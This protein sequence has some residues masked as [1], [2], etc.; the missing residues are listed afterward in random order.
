MSAAWARHDSAARRLVLTLHVLPG[1]RASAIAGVHGDALKVRI[2]APAAENRANAA[3]IDFLSGLFG[4][5]KSAINIR[6]GAK[7]R[8]KLV[9]IAGGPELATKLEPLA[10][11]SATHD[12]R[13]T[14]H[15]HR[16]LRSLIGK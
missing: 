11:R 13:S 12:P 10:S 6:R 15:A 8:R 1:A 16:G 9:E 14:I 3:L 2:A 5:P 4:V 7:G